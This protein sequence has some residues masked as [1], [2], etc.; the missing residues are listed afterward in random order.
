V[1]RNAGELVHAVPVNPT[2]TG[3]VAWIIN[4]HPDY[5]RQSGITVHRVRSMMIEFRRAMYGFPW[6]V[7]PGV[8]V[9]TRCGYDFGR[10]CFIDHEGQLPEYGRPCRPCFRKRS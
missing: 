8:N 7:H 4:A 1:N 9:V 2:P 6:T 3:L 10:E 5:A